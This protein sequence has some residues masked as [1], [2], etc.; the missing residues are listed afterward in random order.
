MAGTDPR[1]KSGDG[2]DDGGAGD[3][4]QN[5]LIEPRSGVLG[6]FFPTSVSLD[7]SALSWLSRPSPPSAWLTAGI[8]AAMKA[9]TRQLAIAGNTRRNLPVIIPRAPVRI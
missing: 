9:M 7:L 1:I 4:A 6:F 8:E 2:H 3:A 5:L